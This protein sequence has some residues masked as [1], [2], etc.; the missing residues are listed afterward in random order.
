MMVSTVM[1]IPCY[2]EAGRLSPEV[3]RSFAEAW[4]HGRFHFV[5]DGSTDDTFAVL[6]KLR[7]CSRSTTPS[8]GQALPN[9][10][11]GQGSIRYPLPVTLDF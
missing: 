3:F 10:R 9:H 5:D 2:N 4:H 7:F 6:S 8:V 1:V 11:H